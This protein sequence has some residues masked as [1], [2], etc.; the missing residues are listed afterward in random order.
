MKMDK[1]TKLGLGSFFAVIGACGIILGP[2]TRSFM[3]FSV[4][5]VLLA[6]DMNLKSTIAMTSIP[7]FS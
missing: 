6:S 7:S 3:S 5:R 1:K 4:S 2:L